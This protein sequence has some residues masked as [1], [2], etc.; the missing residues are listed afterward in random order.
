[1][2]PVYSQARLVAEAQPRRIHSKGTM[3]FI[4][5]QREGYTEPGVMID[6][7]AVGIR[8]EVMGE[9]FGRKKGIVDVDNKNSVSGL[10][11]AM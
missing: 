3:R 8:G 6:N 7:E 10:V 5:I 2:E 9:Q 4:T 1:M 11:T